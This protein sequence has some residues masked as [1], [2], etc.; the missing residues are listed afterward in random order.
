VRAVEVIDNALTFGQTEDI[1]KVYPSLNAHITKL[2]NHNDIEI[3]H[4]LIKICSKYFDLSNCCGYEIWGH[5]DT[6][7]EGWHVDKDE[8][9]HKKGINKYPLCSIIYYIDI[10]IYHKGKLLVNTGKKQENISPRTNR[11]VL[12]S[13][14]VP[15]CVEQ[16][17]GTREVI[18]INPW[19]RELG[20][21][22]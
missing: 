7:P 5:K 16:F 10:N 12:L 19:D 8:I 13:P 21:E 17:W 6:R 2:F 20:N 22:G 18:I 4:P 9:L 3:F 15:H 14:K 1:R 11:L